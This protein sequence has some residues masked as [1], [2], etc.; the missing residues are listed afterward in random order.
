MP[1]VKPEDVVSFV[2]ADDKIRDHLRR[3]ELARSRVPFRDYIANFGVYDLGEVS[4]EQMF[5]LVAARNTAPIIDLLQIPRGRDLLAGPAAA[6]YDIHREKTSLGPAVHS[7]LSQVPS[8]ERDLEVLRDAEDIPEAVPEDLLLRRLAPQEFLRRLTEGELLRSAWVQD[9]LDDLKMAE[10]LEQ[11]SAARP[12]SSVAKDDGRPRGYLLLD[13]SE[14]MGSG[15]DKR[16]EVARG[17]ALA[18]LLSQYESGNP[19][20]LYLF[21]HELSAEIGGEG[22][23]AFES[24]VSAVLAHSYEGMTHLQ[25]ALRLL[26]ENMKVKYSRVDIALISDGATRLTENPVPDTHL[27]TFLVGV[28]PEELDSFGAKQ[29]QESLL[30][31]RE[32]SDFFFGMEPEILKRASVPRKED[33]LDAARLLYGLEREW[34]V[35]ATPDKVRRMKGRVQNL[36]RLC[37]RYREIE[38]RDEEIEA[39]LVQAHAAQTKYGAANPEEVVLANSPQWNPVD[40]ELA[41]AIEVRECGSILR[42]PTLGP[43]WTVQTQ[44]ASE[45]ANPIEVLKELLRAFKIWLRRH[46]PRFGRGRS[47]VA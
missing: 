25:E 4:A 46:R 37:E 31:L 11:D 34:E 45:L 5:A 16:G 17:L 44:S 20:V 40:R 32:W 14:S 7:F 38:R 6:S 33:V 21:R 22:R 18:Y 9:D 43:K 27:H 10:I 35:A 15:R 3:S 26:S 24:A 8:A 2:I 28:R 36:I 30:K 12:E 23:I 1:L 13:T 47:R 19:T 41:M 42:G 39:V 29:Y